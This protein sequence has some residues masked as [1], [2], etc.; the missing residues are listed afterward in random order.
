MPHLLSGD[1]KGFEQAAVNIISNAIQNSRNKGLVK[2]ILSF[3]VKR[4]RLVLI[5]ADNG[6][7]MTSEQAK[8]IFN[9]S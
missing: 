1:E 9:L 5:V 7:G 8:L 3:D 4:S 2:V 6:Q